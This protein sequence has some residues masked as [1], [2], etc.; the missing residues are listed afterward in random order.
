MKTKT[1]SIIRITAI[2]YFIIVIFSFCVII[3]CD[4]SKKL[5]NAELIERAQQRLSSL[6]ND[7]DLFKEN[8]DIG[9]TLRIDTLLSD[10]IIMPKAISFSY[11]EYFND[12]FKYRV[13]YPNN[14]KE[15]QHPQ[16]GDGCHFRS[17]D[18][19]TIFTVYGYWNNA[20]MNDGT[21]EN[22][23]NDAVADYGYSVQ[24]KVLKSN[25][26]VIFGV[27]S[28]KIY[29]QVTKWRGDIGVTAI[30]EYNESDKEL[31]NKACSTILNS[32]TLTIDTY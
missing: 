6:K 22:E 21:I 12:R 16:N 23:Y 31:Y 7:Y 27:K 26:F 19:T 29:Y 8:K 15:G 32:L 5:K 24:Y 1:H 10:T 17:S 2:P 11:E 28:G 25:Y 30:L 9:D 13:K 4:Y 3:S 20:Y 18:G 14:L